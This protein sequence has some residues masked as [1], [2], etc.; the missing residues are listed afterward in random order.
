MLKTYRVV[1]DVLMESLLSQVANSGVIERSTEWEGRV[2]FG[3][4]SFGRK[5]STKRA[6]GRAQASAHHQIESVVEA[7]REHGQLRDYRP[8][9]T[10]ELYKRSEL[11][12][13][14]PYVREFNIAA[15]PV[16]LPVPEHLQDV[17]GPILTVWVC[18]PI[19]EVGF[20]DKEHDG[21]FAWDWVGTYVFLVEE[22]REASVRP[23]MSGISALCAV[24]NFVAGHDPCGQPDQIHSC[25][26]K[27]GEP[28]GRDLSIHPI[29]KLSKVGG[30]AGRKRNI[31]TVYKIVHMTNE[32]ATL[33]DGEEVRLNDIL[34]Y[35]LYIAE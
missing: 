33:I 27:N 28:W 3:V 11:M 5:A 1:N 6:N 24:V 14:R 7:L 21:S 9:R 29:E 20:I 25:T 34:A 32:Q 35:P 22:I 16:Y 18:D 13:D 8:E 12:P 31:E 30:I 19:G 17:R 23:F 2:T 26:R 4:G 15:T 10:H